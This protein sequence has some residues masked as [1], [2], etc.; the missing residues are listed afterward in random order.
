MAT[1]TILFRGQTRRKGE[2]TSISGIPLPGIWVAGGVFPQNKGYDYAI[3]Y[4]QNPKVE[5]YVVHADTI[6][7]YT[8]INDSLGNF[9]FEDDIITFWLKNDATRT[10]RKGVVEYSESSAR[11]MVRVCESTD[12]VMLKDCCCIHVIGNVFDGEFDKSESEMKQLYTECLNLAKSI[13]AI[14]LCY[15]PDIDALKA[16]NL[17]DMAV[18]LLDG[19]S[20]RDVSSGVKAKPHCPECDYSADDAFVVKDRIMNEAMNVIADNTEL[21]ENFAETVKRE[22]ANDDGSY[23]HIGFHLANDIRNQS[24]ASEVLLTLCGWNIDTLL[25][26]TPPIAIED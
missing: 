16:E 12:V 6:G 25:D 2:R 20:R 21:A 15:N 26:K 4:Q 9:I 3:I 11:F 24:P 7:Q 19:V 18:R 5:K 23:A 14:M 10:R 8:G 22:I 1:R 13:D 17:S